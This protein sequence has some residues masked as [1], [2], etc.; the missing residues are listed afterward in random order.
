MQ[1]LIVPPGLRWELIIVDNGTIDTSARVVEEFAE[2]L[3]IRR[4]EEPVQGICPA[5][6]RAV[7]E[8]RGD[9]ICWTDDDTILDPHWLAAYVAAF[10]RHPDAAIFGGRIL[11]R[12][13]EPV[14]RW[15]RNSLDCWQLNAVFVHRDFDQATKIGVS[16]DA[17]PWGANFAVRAAEQRQFEYDLELGMS[18]NHNRSGDESDV[19][20]RMLTGGCRGWWVPESIVHH[21]V[22]TSRQTWSYLHFYFVRAAETAAFA[23]TGFADQ[24]GSGRTL[25]RLSRMSSRRLYAQIALDWTLFLGAAAAGLFPRAVRFLA[26]AGF[27]RGVLNSR[28]GGA[29]CRSSS[30][31]TEA[32]QAAG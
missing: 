1:D 2:A 17:T 3:P 18:P 14:P 15:V 28:K 12:M 19:L 21:A 24:D 20:Y 9:Y 27:I 29:Q 32:V 4:V 6:N 7:R 13:E 30:P 5:R 10:V 11:R 22:P 25:C 31:T 8:A 16:R 26:S 23:G